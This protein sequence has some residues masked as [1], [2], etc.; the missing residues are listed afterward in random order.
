[1]I[2]K[3]PLIPSLLVDNN[4]IT[5]IGTKANVFNKFLAEQCIPLKNGS[6]RPINQLFLTQSR[7][8]TMISM[9]TKY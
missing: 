5:D 8:G 9:K 4:F 2:K 1:M 7:L 6:V 3:N